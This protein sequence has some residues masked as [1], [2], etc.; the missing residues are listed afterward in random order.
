LVLASTGLLG[1]LPWPLLPSL[2]SVPLVVAPSATA[3]LGACSEPPTARRRVLAVS[4]PGI[5]RGS[6]EARR[7][8]AI[9]RGDCLDGPAAT[10]AAVAD[11]LADGALVHVAAHGTHQG[12]NPLFSSLRLADGDLFAHELHLKA[13]AA[14]HV[15]LSACELGL[16]TVRPGDEALGLTSVLLRLGTRAVVAGVAR[17]NDEVAAEVLVD[18]HRRLAAGSDSAHA[19]AAAVAGRG[20]AADGFD[21]T[22]APFVCFGSAWRA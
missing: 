11:A 14:D 10:T 4:G 6:D 16:A 9:W 22:P 12:E 7:V 15:V 13:R 19:L 21:V 2:R 18:Y 1:Q 20:A 17:V 5:R 3:W 8:A